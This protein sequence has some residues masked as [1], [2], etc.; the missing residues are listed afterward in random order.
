MAN[1]NHM[2]ADVYDVLQW[3]FTRSSEDGEQL[4]KPSESFE[5]FLSQHFGE[6]K[7]IGERS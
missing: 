7:V 1:L 4:L 5:W 2:T 6:A 3:L